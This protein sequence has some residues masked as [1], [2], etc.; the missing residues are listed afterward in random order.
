MNSYF[1][2]LG[3]LLAFLMAWIDPEPGEMLQ[4]MGLIPWMVVTIFLINGYHTS[5]KQL[6]RGR[7]ILKASIIAILISLL[8]SPF[9]GLAVIS[10]LPLPAG[11]AIGL[12]VMATV[13]PTLS[14]GIVMTGIAGG[15][16]VQALFLT[17]LLNLIGVFTIPF[18]LQFTLES[19]NIA[20][21]SPLPLLKQLILIVL[22]PFVAGMLLKSA[23]HIPVRHWLL[24]YLP[25]SCVIATVWMSV[26]ASADTLKALNLQL[27]LSIAVAAVAVHG[28]L[29]L[30]CWLSRYLFR[31][32]RSDWLALLFTASQKTL[33]V[34]IG[35]LAALNQPIGLAMV[36]CI[37]FHFLQL[38]IDSMIASK[39]GKTL[40]NEQTVQTN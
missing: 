11:A 16:V 12:V 6:P 30:L 9:F 22:I 27:L 32:A 14:S 34:A 8:I 20:S 40:H 28:F 19:V 21:I 31:P 4:Q 10:V 23:I 3:L 29:L 1:L 17:I 5:L 36:A 7:N 39:M 33:P 2:P 13:P 24:R 37:I 26:S 25:S 35:V 38:F 15:N 18:M